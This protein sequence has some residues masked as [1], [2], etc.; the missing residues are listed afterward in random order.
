[1][2]A[3][4]QANTNG[5]LHS[6]DQP[7]IS[8]LNRGF[9]YGDAIYE[10]WRTYHGVLFAW[11]EHWER[12]LR[13]AQALYFK[14]PFSSE[15]IFEEIKKTV[16][17]YRKHGGPGTEVY[18]RLQ[19]TRGIG[20]IG[21]DPALA[22]EAFFVILVQEN[23]PY[24]P[25]KI[26]SGLH[27][28]IARSLRRNSPEA[29]DPAWKT[30]NY[31]NNI[32]CLRE[33]RERGADEVVICNQKGEITEAA[34]SNIAFVNAGAVVTPPLSAGIL[35]GVTRR[36]LIEKVAP[37]LQVSVRQQ[38]IT[39]EDIS[40]MTECFILSST[41]D[42]TPVRAIDTQVFSVAEGSV[43]MK[44]KKGFADLTESYATAHPELRLI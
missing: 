33:A 42:L 16:E 4:I 7:S 31:L 32:L 41:K 37:L 38:S 2:S 9:L 20:A 27:L 26:R 24:P 22:D 15:R 40:Q 6:A 25:E 12:L 5:Q 3:Y 13:S 18:V 8:P 43:T 28:S 34:V 29:L 35:A 19:I 23:K 11:E 17:A 21:L 44:L 30:G 14:I 39:P 1:M 36:F 10:V